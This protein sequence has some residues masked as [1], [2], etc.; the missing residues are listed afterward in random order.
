MRVLVLGL[1]NRLLGDDAA[2]PLAIEA[3]ADEPTAGPA[4]I[5]WRDGGTL[6]LSLL[7]EIEAA[8]ALLVV[9]AAR[10]DAPVGEVRRFEGAAMDAQL[11]G[12]KRSAH[13]LALG[14]LLGAAA[15]IGHLPARRALVA[16]QPA[17][18]DVGLALSP[19]VAAAFPALCAAVRS[20]LTDWIGPTGGQAPG[21]ADDA[22]TH[23]REECVDET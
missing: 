11:G 5:V 23:R 19:E 13:E 15:L 14:D 16:V 22:V 17:H 20:T 6:G 1:G 10:F 18:T 3:L 4:E 2:G 7:P 12:R 21:R 9:D 8:D